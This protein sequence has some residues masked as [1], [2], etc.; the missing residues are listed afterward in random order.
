LPASHYPKPVTGDSAAAAPQLVIC[1]GLHSAELTTLFLR[2]LQAQWLTTRDSPLACLVAPVS[3]P[4]YSP[5]AFLAWLHHHYDL[6][7]PLL[8]LGFSAGVVG[9]MGAA[10]GWQLAGGKVAGLIALDGWGVGLYGNFPVYR[11]S[12]DEFT[13]WSS[14]LLGGGPDSFYAQPSCTHL[15][16]WSQP[17]QAQ[18]YWVTPEGKIPTQAAEFLVTVLQRYL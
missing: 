16:L 3:L 5:P 12:H 15:E 18:G 9:A 14:H 7:V 1:P 11:L 2:S 17:K 10:W 8:L 4:I 6:D 13:H